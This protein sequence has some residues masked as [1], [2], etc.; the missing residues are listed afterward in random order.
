MFPN[1]AQGKFFCS[2]CNEVHDTQLGD[3]VL[4]SGFTFLSEFGQTFHIGYCE[5]TT[6]KREQGAVTV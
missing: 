4:K 1:V 3:K 6:A 2:N 5:K